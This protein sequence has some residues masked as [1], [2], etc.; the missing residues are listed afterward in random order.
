MGV[1]VGSPGGLCSFHK[2]GFSKGH[3]SSPVSLGRGRRDGGMG[4]QTVFLC[5]RALPRQRR[6][7]YPSPNS[8]ASLSSTA[9]DP[10]I[11]LKPLLPS[12]APSLGSASHFPASRSCQQDEGVYCSVR[13]E[14]CWPREARS[15]PRRWRQLCSAPRQH[16]AASRAPTGRA[17][18]GEQPGVIS[19]SQNPKHVP[20]RGSAEKNLPSAGLG[21]VSCPGRAK[22]KAGACGD[23]Q[24][25][26]GL[27]FAGPRQRQALGRQHGEGWLQAAAFPLS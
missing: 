16:S 27:G 14:T 18:W 26:A 13:W 21:Q 10:S 20:S 2:A 6:L 19:L 9:P 25:F 15:R 4:G 24:S 5:L 17:G 12:S 8:C 11:V 1:P 22:R 23:G 3:G 7:E